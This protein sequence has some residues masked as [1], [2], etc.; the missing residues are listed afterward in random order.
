MLGVLTLLKLLDL[1]VSVAFARRFDPLGDPVYVGAGVSF[2]RDAIG[3]A[4]AWTVTV[5]AV[6]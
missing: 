5:L 6:R 4:N 1:G 3:T 2:L